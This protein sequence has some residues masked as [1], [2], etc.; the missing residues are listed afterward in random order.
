[1]LT[2]PFMSRDRSPNLYRRTC[3]FS[4][5]DLLIALTILG[6]LLG[7]AL[8]ALRNAVAR[9]QATSARTA[10]TATLFDAQ[11]NATV[12][13]REI[14]VCPATATQCI[15]GEDWSHGWIAFIDHDSD[16]LHGPGDQ[17]V[18]QEEK[19]PAGVRLHGTSGRPR[20]VYQPNGGSAGT[21]I[22]FTLCDRRGPKSAQALI[23]SNGA[24]LRHEP[25]KPAAAA[26]C[27]NGL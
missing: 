1:M 18:R 25:A 24:R 10:I 26:A 14:V 15:G 4:L 23:L 9:V 27:A 13:G 8:P 20:I 19:L 7:I 21:N 2:E 12:I 3:G 17:I 11:R 5:L 22:T 6:I 16:R